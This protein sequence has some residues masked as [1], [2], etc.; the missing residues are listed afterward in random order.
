M[1]GFGFP[2]QTRAQQVGRSGEAYIER[3][4]TG[5]LG[6]V[7]RP[8]HRES[9]FGIDGFIDVVTAGCVTGRGL[10]VQIKCG[11]SYVSKTTDGGIRYEGSNQHLNYYLN[12]S[13]P[14][15]LVVLSSNCDEGYWVKFDIN[16]T[17]ETSTG[18]WIEIPRKNLLDQSVAVRWAQIAGP[19]EDYSEQIQILWTVDEVLASTDF[20]SIVIPA[21]EIHQCSMA[22]ITDLLN[23]L[24]KTRELVLANRGKLEIFFPGYDSDSRE[25][26][27]IPEVRRWVEVSIDS[28]VPWFYFLN[29][30]GR[31]DSLRLLLFCTCEVGVKETHDN[32]HLLVTEPE[33]RARWLIR[34]FDN[35][36]RFT[37][38]HDIPL[39]INQ[40]RCDAVMECLDRSIA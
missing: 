29:T 22:F 33:E 17:N 16:R 40:E 1:S 30:R 28:G 2:K 27:E 9:D 11:D 36:N 12:H 35:L 38:D 10:A 20:R 39:E 24:S 32:R 15:V 21:E 26:Y 37:A 23:R 18:W 3:F 5:E 7:Y 6:W 14:V 34:N 31:G 4:V 8:V 25:I 13:I 19:V